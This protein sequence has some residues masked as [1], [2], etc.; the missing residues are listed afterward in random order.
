MGD[1]N[2]FETETWLQDYYDDHCTYEH[3]KSVGYFSPNDIL[4]LLF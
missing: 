1:R 3:C 2:Y 4:R